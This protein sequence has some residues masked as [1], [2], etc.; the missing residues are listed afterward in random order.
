MESLESTSLHLLPEPP[1]PQAAQRTVWQIRCDWRRIKPTTPGR[2]KFINYETLNN[3]LFNQ[4]V[5]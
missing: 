3:Y 1:H 2:V 5:I 4:R